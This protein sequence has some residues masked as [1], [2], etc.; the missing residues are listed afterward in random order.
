MYDKKSK[1]NK[2][3]TPFILGGVLILIII[4]LGNGLNKSN[5]NNYSENNNN[6]LNEESKIKGN[7][8]REIFS[9][10]SFE[11]ITSSDTAVFTFNTDSTFEVNY[12]GGNTYKGTYEVYNGLFIGIKANEIEKD[13]NIENNTM[14]AN[15]INN[16]ANKMIETDLLNTYLLWLETDTN[17]LQPYMISYNPDTQ[18]GVAVNIFGRSQGTFNKK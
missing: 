4:V 3:K 7:Y 6:F 12:A 9:G 1:D 2:K 13:T 5:D 10:N 15:D 14:L 17:I 16:V 18:S 8:S 11:C